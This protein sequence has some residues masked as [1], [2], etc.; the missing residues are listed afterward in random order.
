[1]KIENSDD[2]LTIGQADMMELLLKPDV[3]V[4]CTGRGQIILKTNGSCTLYFR[5]ETP[6]NQD[7]SISYALQPLVEFNDVSTNTEKV[8]INKVRERLYDFTTDEKLVEI[9]F[10]ENTTSKESLENFDRKL[11]S[12]G[13]ISEKNIQV[14]PDSEKTSKLGEYIEAGGNLI[15]KGIDFSS[16]WITI[17]IT[18]GGQELK[19][20]IKPLDEPTKIDPKW[21]SSFASASNATSSVRGATKAISTTAIDFFSYIID[22]S[23]GRSLKSGCPAVKS[24]A[25]AS[26]RVIDTL[27]DAAGNILYATTDTATELIEHRYG[28]NAANVAQHGGNVAK[29]S[30]KAQDNIRKIGT[31][32]IIKAVGKVAGK[33]NNI[34]RRKSSDDISEKK[35]DN[36]V[37]K[38]E[39]Y[40]S[41]TIAY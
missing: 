19:K 24:T 38:G 27:G 3:H 39:F 17:G 33:Q 12:L 18:K 22:K 5:K 9:H 16:Y 40:R 11:V 36:I 15:C 13:L 14:D 30:Y 28:Q 8:S 4:N 29:N 35:D 41:A 21:E 37:E 10:D 25:R 23:M 2:F 6:N 26:I 1:M 20:S 31:R 34:S 7:N 32:S